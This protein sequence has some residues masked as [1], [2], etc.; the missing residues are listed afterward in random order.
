MALWWLSYRLNDRPFGAAIVRASTLDHARMIAVIDGIDAGFT[1][2]EGYM[3]DEA[4]S[5]AI[6][7]GEIGRFLFLPQAEEIEMRFKA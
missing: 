6:M 7:P 4:Q 1:F 3:L 2:A 5:R